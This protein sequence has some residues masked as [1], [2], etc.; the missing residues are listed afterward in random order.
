[1]LVFASR[2]KYRNT[3]VLQ[4]PSEIVRR[5]NLQSNSVA[6][7]IRIEKINGKDVIVLE[8]LSR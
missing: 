3:Y 5:L 1:M 8:P 4:I 2:R 6:F 7:D